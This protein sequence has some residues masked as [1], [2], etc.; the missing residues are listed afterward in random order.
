MRTKELTPLNQ[1]RK[2]NNVS[3]ESLAQSVGLSYSH[4][5]RILKNTPKDIMLSTAVD[6]AK[7]SGLDV[8]DLV[9]K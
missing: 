3:I 8:D 6:L 7:I 2:E 9:T 1:W 4:M 5:R